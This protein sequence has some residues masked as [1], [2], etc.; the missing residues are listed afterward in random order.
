MQSS[1]KTDEKK[2][3]L[4]VPSWYPSQDDP[5]SGIFI[6][7]QAH[8]LSAD[9][10]VAVLIPR[11]TGWRN[12][13]RSNNSSLKADER[14][15]PVFRTSARPLIPHGPEFTSHETFVRAAQKGFKRVLKEWGRP[16]V[17][18]AHVVLPAGW[19]ALNLAKQYE[20]PIV[21]TEHSGP[22][23]MHVGTPLQKRLV[24]QTLTEVDRVIAVSMALADQIVTVQRQV[25]LR[26][27][28]ELVRTDFFVPSH[29]GL[30]A[31]ARENSAV[32]FLFAGRL[33]AEKGVTNLIGAVDK[34][35]Q[36]GISS[37]ELIIGGDG[38]DRSSLET[39]V[40]SLGL[41]DRCTFLGALNREE[42]RRAMQHCDVFVLPSLSE[43][44]GIVLGEAMA[45]G[46]P[47]IAT[48]CGGPDTIV[49]PDTGVLVAIGDPEALSN[50]MADFISQ[51]MTFDSC[52]VRESVV[53]RF[54]PSA[55]LNK[56][57]HIY[58]E[59][60]AKRSEG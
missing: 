58:E 7:E 19:A 21:L 22:F 35:A 2:K 9:Y 47:V 5:I 15:V 43:T 10:D 3:V 56:V 59:L 26:I 13:L 39:L 27:V 55:F 52:K 6:Q 8:A 48:R 44:F 17:I 37:F 51:R 41:R 4:I 18:H 33:S 36:R 38:P 25:Q 24:K 29:N 60:W 30:G 14:G 11:M 45:C 42:V 28:G 34:L 32:R 40:D 49:T 50:A 31:A 54:G 53:N 16:D 46:K 1:K 12:V 57:S 23:S 20:I